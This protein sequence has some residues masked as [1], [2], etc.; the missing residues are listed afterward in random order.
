MRGR[1]DGQGEDPGDKK[2]TEWVTPAGFG[3]TSTIEKNTRSPTGMA[4]VSRTASPRRRV[5]RSSAAVWARSAFT[6]LLVRPVSPAVSRRKTSS[7]RCRPARRSRSATSC[8]DSQAVRAAIVAGRPGVRDPVLAGRLL[9]DL[10]LE[11]GAERAVVQ[12]GLGGEADLGREART[13]GGS[14]SRRG[15][16]GLGALGADAG[17]RARGAPVLVPSPALN[18]PGVPAATTRPRS[19]ITTRSARRSASSSSWVVSNTHTPAARRSAMTPRMICRPWGSTPAV[20][21]SRNTTSGR[22]I[23]ARAR[24]RRC[25]SPPDSRRQGVRATGPARPERDRRRSGSSGSG[26]NSWR[27]D[28]QPL[29]GAMAGYTPPCCSITPTRRVRRLLVI[30]PLRI[31]AQDPDRPGRG[32]PVALA[33]STVLVLPA[34]LRPRTATTSPGDADRS[35]PSTATTDP[36]RTTRPDTSTAGD[37]VTGMGDRT[38]RAII[39]PKEAANTSGA[40]CTRA[41]RWSIM[42]GGRG[43]GCAPPTLEAG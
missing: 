34:P 19:M 7:R 9:A 18:S 1:H 2:S 24:E 23:R 39:P 17:G 27:R 32:A 41:A 12:P 21:S 33:A 38:Y 25:C 20:G 29:G 4:M 42:Y 15:R 43:S 11:P 3:S 22:P 28:A 8:S 14:T 5:R 26:R 13:R 30:G 40:G 37:S 36:Y 10:G 16:G 31:E 6:L 35:T